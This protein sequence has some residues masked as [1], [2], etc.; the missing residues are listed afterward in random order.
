[1]TPPVIDGHAAPRASGMPS[2]A[3]ITPRAPALRMRKR[4]HGD[5]GIVG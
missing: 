3:T 4:R 1:M 2:T 5:I